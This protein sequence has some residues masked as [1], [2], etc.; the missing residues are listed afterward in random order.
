MTTL[1]SFEGRQ[2]LYNKNNSSNAQSAHKM[3][4]DGELLLKP[5][6][7]DFGLPFFASMEKSPMKNETFD[8][9]NFCS[10]PI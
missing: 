5:L 2:A 8:V 10:V 3:I 4:T 6:P 1:G 7:A 9:A